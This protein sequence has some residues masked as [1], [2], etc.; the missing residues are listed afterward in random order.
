MSEPPH[1]GEPADGDGGR[2]T[3][4]RL[5][6]TLGLAVDRVGLS[7]R[8]LVTY[9]R[10]HVS[11]RTPSQPT[12]RDGNTLDLV[13]PPDPGDL[14]RWIARFGETVAI[15]GARHV[16]LRWETPLAAD[17]GPV[18][19]TP[20][21][22]LAAAVAARGMSLE[23]VTVLLLDQL[24]PVASSGAELA[25]LAA[26]RSTDEPAS[27]TE[28]RWHGIEVLERYVQGD[29]PDQ[30]RPD[31]TGFA[32]FVVEV[33]RELARAGRAQV[34]LAVRQGVPAGRCVVVHDRQ[35]L[36]VVQ[37]VVVHPVHRRRGLASALT[38]AAATGF[39]AEQPD[40]ARLG[41]GAEPGGPADH[42]YRRLG[43]R[44][45]AT[46]WTALRPAPAPAS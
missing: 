39:L 40:G 35:G 11:V 25:R 42:L 31:D 19:P 22:D 41:I 2:P 15:L 18:P 21:P 16:Q 37:D 13:A 24:V 45:H 3:V 12:F 32:R 9:A 4:R 20:D 23:A 14:D 36:G 46:V 28:R 44:P 26:P 38:H 27:T 43:F 29:A 5:D 6:T 8:S 1:P 33:R 10:D 34:W 7:D 17:A 30:W